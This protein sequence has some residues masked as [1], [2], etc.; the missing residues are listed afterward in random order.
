MT[1]KMDDKN[2]MESLLFSVKT[3]SGLFYNGTVEST[4]ANVRNAFDSA[5]NKSL[6]MQ[7]EIY[8]KMNEKGWY[9]PTSVEQQKIS[10]T[11]Q[12]FSQMR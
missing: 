5:L 8:S 3:T 6:Q 10:Q 1:L 4:T 7:N 9:Q 11:A 2:L 12:K